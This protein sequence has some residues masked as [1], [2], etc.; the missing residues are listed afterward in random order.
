M[1]EWEMN[2]W[3]LHFQRHSACLSKPNGSKKMHECQ[4]KSSVDHWWK[5]IHILEPSVSLWFDAIGIFRRSYCK[6]WE[7]TIFR[8]SAGHISFS[9]CISW[10]RCHAVSCASRAASHEM[11]FE[12]SHGAIWLTWQSRLSANDP[13]TQTQ[14]SWHLDLR[15]RKKYLKKKLYP[16]AMSTTPFQGRKTTKTRTPTPAKT[17]H[18]I[19]VVLTKFT[20]HTLL[21]MDDLYRSRI[22]SINSYNYKLHHFLDDKWLETPEM[23]IKN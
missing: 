17:R 11:R 20:I 22:L 3:W 7:V 5:L 4:S 8:V 21:I 9:P 10:R 1:E 6:F 15:C 18:C 16:R 14:E 12:S 23:M 2:P 19:C 13:W